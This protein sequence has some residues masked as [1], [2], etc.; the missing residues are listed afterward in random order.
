MRRVFENMKLVTLLIFWSLPLLS[1][2]R[3]D[4]LAPSHDRSHLNPAVIQ[5]GSD[6]SSPGVP[7]FPSSGA[8]LF[9]EEDTLDDV[10]F[11]TGLLLASSWRILLSDP[12]ASMARSQ[13]IIPRDPSC[14][15]PLRC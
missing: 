15:L 13:R 8:S 6:Q 2:G 3:S 4:Q 11:D 5:Y 12:F 7:R 9:D 1:T 10:L 14:P